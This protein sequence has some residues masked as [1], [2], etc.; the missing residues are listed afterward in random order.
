MICMN[1]EELLLSR[2]DQIITAANK[3][4]AYDIRIFGSVARGDYGQDSDID[5][6]IKLEAGRSLLDVARLLRELQA[7]LGVNVDI[8]TEAGLRSRLREQ[9]LKEARAL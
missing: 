7:L 6:L 8:V 9:V 3:Y 4:G 1:Q 2:R 5:F